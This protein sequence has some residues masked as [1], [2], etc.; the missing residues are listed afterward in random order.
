LS[1]QRRELLAAASSAHFKEKTVREDMY[2]VIVERPRV[3]GSHSGS[4]RH[5]RNQLDG[6]TH[7]GMRAYYFD[8]RSLNENLSPLRR[9]LHAQVGRPWNKVFAEICAR[10]DR[11]N[12]VQRHIHQ[13]IAHFIAI[14]VEVQHGRLFD[15]STDGFR[16]GGSRVY[17][18]LYVDPRT[19]LVR[20][21]PDARYPKR[22]RAERRRQEEAQIAARRRVIDDNTLL[23]K[24][25]DAWFEVKIARLPADVADSRHDVVLHRP[26]TRK[27]P[28]NGNERL[29]LYGSAAHYAVAKRQLSRRE[30][31]KHGLRS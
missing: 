11:R 21:N 13:H 28:G 15:R 17:Q 25:A 26:I 18:D 23:L 7:L 30:L 2:K 31:K 24:L 1:R 9:Y 29:R 27:G 8:R 6:P 14:H 20:I 12:T 4:V 10:I 19:G 16:T 5:L 22:R 3:G